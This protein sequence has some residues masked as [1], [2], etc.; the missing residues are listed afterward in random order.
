MVNDTP[1]NDTPAYGT[2]T[3]ETPTNETSTNDTPMNNK[4]VNDTSTDDTPADEL[5]KLKAELEKDQAMFADL[6]KEIEQLKT[7]VADLSKAVAEIDQKVKAWEKASAALK[8]Q[9]QAQKSYFDR[10][11]K[12]L[13]ATLSDA[14][15]KV[16]TTAKTKGEDNVAQLAQQV[17]DLKQKVADKQTALAKAKDTTAT[18]QKEYKAQVELAT[19]DDDLLKDLKTLHTDADKEEAKN[20]ILRMYFLILEG[21]A[22]LKKLDV[23]E[24]K[25]YADRLNK[26]SAALTDATTA[27]QAAK[28]ELDKAQVDLQKAEKDLGDADK[29]R[30]QTTLASIP[31]KSAVN[32]P[33]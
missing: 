14:D 17:K 31:E 10:E 8:E 32:A 26:T 7:K 9:Q 15:K 19:K 23:P 28:A 13:E 25:E 30:R 33:G 11:Q 6:G 27:E 12:E 1:M 24:V 3:N 5:A 4:A 18:R 22:D 29:S 16:V 21:E 2:P 20:N